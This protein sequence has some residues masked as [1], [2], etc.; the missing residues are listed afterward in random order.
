MV[1]GYTK[2]YYAGTD[3]CASREQSQACLSYAETKQSVRSN[4]VAARLGGGGLNALHVIE[5]DGELQTKADSLFDQCLEQVNSRVLNEND[6]ECIMR[7]RFAR[8]EFG[9]RID[10][11]PYQTKADISF[12]HRPFKEMAYLMADDPVNV[13]END[14]YFYHSDHLGSASWITDSAGIA[15]QHLQYLPYG[16]PYINQH[17]YGYSERFTFTGKEKDEETGYGYFGARYM[18]HEL[19][20]MWLSVDPLSD[21]YPSISPYNYCMWNPIKL[22]DP[23]GNEGIIVS[24]S[25]GNHNNKLHFLENGLDRAKQCREYNKKSGEQTTWIIYNDP[26][27]QTSKDVISRYSKEAKKLGINVM[28]VDNVD[29]I[30][31]YINNK[32]GN[33]SR[34]KDKI[35]RF[36]YVG[37]ATPGDLD[38]GFAG[39]GENFDPGDLKASA[40]RSGAYVD[41]VGGCRTAVADR[42]L[43]GAIT[44]ESSVVDQFAKILDKKSMVVGSDVRV[45]Y[46]GGVM[47]NRQL[48]AENKG[49]E[50]KKH[51][52][53]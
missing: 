16:E 46:N 35:S 48:L 6:L 34:E 24:G 20:T 13:A 43:F 50:V 4:R 31:D 12:D 15:V 52:R 53:L 40:F 39:S 26:E 22:I 47:T 14:V 38:V 28:V 1:K 9:Y 29:D 37:H 51:G 21:K 10:E 5:N 41:V 30:T 25:P 23:D 8:A 2:H 17:P 45:H 33:G 36:Y 27:N 32:D 3:L 7:N 19:M 44:V 49:R 18:D 42:I 11:T